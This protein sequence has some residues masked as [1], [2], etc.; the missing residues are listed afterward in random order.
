[1]AVDV[2][3]GLGVGWVSILSQWTLK[4]TGQEHDSSLKISFNT[5]LYMN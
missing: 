1:M 2:K 5:L 4:L 3:D